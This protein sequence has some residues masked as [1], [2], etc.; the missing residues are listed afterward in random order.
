MSYIKVDNDGP[1]LKAESPECCNAQTMTSDGASL[2]DECIDINT[3]AGQDATED[4]ETQ[5]STSP[6]QTSDASCSGDFQYSG[7]NGH[8]LL[9]LTQH[10]KRR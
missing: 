10:I 2:K 9:I 6:V 1:G 7:K 4:G 5:E 3:A 8:N